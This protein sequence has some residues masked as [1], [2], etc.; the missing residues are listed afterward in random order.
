MTTTTAIIVA[1]TTTIATKIPTQASIGRES[2]ESSVDVAVEGVELVKGEDNAIEIELDFADVIV[3]GFVAAAVV[4]V[5]EQSIPL[6]LYI[7]HSE[8]YIASS[9]FKKNY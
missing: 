6:G 4:V 7:S 3:V 2:D 9:C 1:K 5:L 8:V